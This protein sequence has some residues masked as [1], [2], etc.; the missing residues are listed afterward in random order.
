MS[1]RWQMWFE[2]TKKEMGKSESRKPSLKS[3]SQMK[4]HI[5]TLE[6]NVVLLE[7]Y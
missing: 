5:T 4:C 6:L 1:V 7:L 3:E 2:K